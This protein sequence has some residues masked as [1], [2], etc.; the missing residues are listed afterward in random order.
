MTA[1]GRAFLAVAPPPAVLRWTESVAESARRID[2][3]L[4]WCAPGQQHLTLQFLGRVDDVESL[5]E[6]VVESV[7]G[8]APFALALGGAGAFPSPPRASVVWLAV[9]TGAAELGA[10]AGAIGAAT[11]RLGFAAADRPF[12]PHL[13]LARANA[14]H[15]ARDVVERLC[16]GPAGPRFTVDRV[17]LFDSDTR[18]DGAVHTERRRFVLLGA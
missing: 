14:A 3:G 12:R 11:A 16:A 15:D 13:T 17:V 4:R 2:D 8:I 9:S 7:R 6:S 10:L 5:A 1:L 18:P